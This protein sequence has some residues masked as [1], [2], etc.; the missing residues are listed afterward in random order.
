MISLTIYIILFI[1]NVISVIANMKAKKFSSA[2]FNLFVASF[3]LGMGLF[4]INW[5][6]FP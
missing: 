3:M 4:V 6:N 1:L 5:S 2:M